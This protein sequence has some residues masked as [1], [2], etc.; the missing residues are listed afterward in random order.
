MPVIVLDVV[1][2]ADIGMVQLRSRASLTFEALQGLGIPDQVFR[3]EL[4]RDA[5]PQPRV[6]GLIH[7]PHATAA[8]FSQDAIVRDCLA[9]H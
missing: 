5:A 8:E 3:D 9:D 4:K 7:H 1:N 6:L 2:S